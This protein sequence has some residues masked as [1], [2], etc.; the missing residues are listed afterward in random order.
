MGL[1]GVVLYKN[2]CF[3]KYVHNLGPRESPDMILRAFDVK[4]HEKKIE[5]PPE[6]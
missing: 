5:I 3:Y 6:A 1:T 4:L 2:T